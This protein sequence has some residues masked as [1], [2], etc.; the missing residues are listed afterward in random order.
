METYIIEESSREDYDLVDSGIVEYNL[1]KVT[2]TQEQ[3][4]IS[5]N[6][7]I[8]DVNGEVLAGINSLLY[9]WNCL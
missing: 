3:P 9:C 6:R 4:F 5:I 1:S 8:K 7:V 2:F